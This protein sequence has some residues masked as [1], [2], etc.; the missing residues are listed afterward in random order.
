MFTQFSTTESEAIVLAMISLHCFISII[1][2][3]FF[4]QSL[5]V[6]VL[7]Q[8]FA[9]HPPLL[10]SLPPSSSTHSCYKPCGRSSANVTPTSHKEMF[11]VLGWLSQQGNIRAK[12]HTHTHTHTH[13]PRLSVQVFKSRLQ[14][15]THR[16]LVEANPA[17]QNTEHWDLAAVLLAPPPLLLE[18]WLC[19]FQGSAHVR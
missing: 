4:S 15:L 5:F 7:C 16:D 8:L 3:N 1:L 11:S 17:N 13:I 18:A 19:G 6:S 2:F 12:T 9:F 14:P 10:L